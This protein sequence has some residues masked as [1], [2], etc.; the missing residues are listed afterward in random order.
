[1]AEEAVGETA[2]TEEEMATSVETTIT[3]ATTAPIIRS[4]K[5]MAELCTS[6]ELISVEQHFQQVL[7]LTCWTAELAITISKKA[8]RLLTREKWETTA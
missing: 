4:R 7:V 1:V 5:K 6:M 2:T 3:A 8:Q